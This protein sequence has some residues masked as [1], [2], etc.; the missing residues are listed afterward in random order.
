MVEVLRRWP[1]FGAGRPPTV[2]T[3]CGDSKSRGRPDVSG[4][5][6]LEER[7]IER[8]GSPRPI[9]VDTRIIAATHRDLD[10]LL[11]GGTFREDRYCHLCVFPIRVPPLRVRAGD[12]ERRSL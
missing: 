7:Q 5:R 10:R 6:V 8:L 12:T 9:R 1:A 3:A 4:L 2:F 11:A